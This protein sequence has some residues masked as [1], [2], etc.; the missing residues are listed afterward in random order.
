MGQSVPRKGDRFEV[1]YP[2]PMAPDYI[3]VLRV[4]KGGDWADVRVRQPTGFSWSK[5]QPLPFPHNWEAK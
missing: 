2:H 4:A 1:R 5:R 3:E